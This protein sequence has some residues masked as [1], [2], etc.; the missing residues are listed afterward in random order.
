MTSESGNKNKAGVL[1]RLREILHRSLMPLGLIFAIYNLSLPHSH[2]PKSPHQAPLGLHT[3]QSSGDSP[4]SPVLHKTEHL[5]FKSL[6]RDQ[7]HPVH[8]TTRGR[9]R[10]PWDCGAPSSVLTILFILPSQ[11]VEK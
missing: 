8:S 1:V 4:C 6:Q 10:R 5:L 2:G 9:P 7:E 3:S 11:Q